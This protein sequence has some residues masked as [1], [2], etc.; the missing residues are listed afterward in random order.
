MLQFVS[1][2]FSIYC[3][4]FASKESEFFEIRYSFIRRQ[5]DADIFHT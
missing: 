2:S 1:F 5:K 4:A 3:A